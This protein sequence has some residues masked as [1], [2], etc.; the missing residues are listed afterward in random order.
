MAR[1]RMIV[2][3]HPPSITLGTWWSKLKTSSTWS[4]YQT[5][6]YRPSRYRPYSSVDSCIDEIHKGPPFKEGGPL[7]VLHYHDYLLNPKGIGVYTGESVT[8]DFEYR[9]GFLCSTK[10]P[11]IFQNVSYTD[12]IKE[13]Y[14]VFEDVSSYGPTAWNR[15]KPGKPAADL[16]LF[17]AELRDMPRMLRD[18]C[19][20]FKDAYKDIRFG[21]IRSIKNAPG[22]YVGTQ[23]GW[24]PFLSDMRKFYHTYQT[25]DKRIKQLKRDNGQWVKREGTVIEESN[26]SLIGEW[27]Y[28]VHNPL[29]SSHFYPAYP[30]LG[31]SIATRHYERK[32]WFSAR[33]RYYI[34]D[35]GS[36]NWNRKAKRLL[37]GGSVNPAL[38]WEAT[39]WSWLI[40]W[41]SNVGDVIANLDNGLAENLTAKYAYLMGTTTVVGKISSNMATSPP[42]NL[43]WIFDVQE[44]VREQANPFGFGLTWD[45]LTLRQWSILGALGLDRLVS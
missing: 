30:Y 25:L 16:A 4:Q 6:T 41:T 26:D 31:H 44:K 7:K 20:F 45:N 36:V 27:P 38:L 9:G 8:G 40:D 19:R 21:G 37:F 39:P 2:A 29:L 34:P 12:I 43:E 28:P 3:N 23:F 10:E 13:N 22:N 1:R 35:I 17:V 33:F 14:E 15:F 24:L 5:T 42:S 11:Y 18:T 32:I